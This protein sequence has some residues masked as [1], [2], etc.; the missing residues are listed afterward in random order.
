[1][2]NSHSLKMSIVMFVVHV[3]V[4]VY[5]VLLL[6]LNRQTA[7]SP[8]V[9]SPLLSAGGCN[10]NRQVRQTDRQTA[11]SPGVTSPLLSCLL[12]ELDTDRMPGDAPS[13]SAGLK[14][15]PSTASLAHC[16]LTA[17]LA[18]SWLTARSAV[19]STVCLHH[20]L[21]GL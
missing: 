8:G 9:T 4:S 2:V 20:S 6:F 19:S 13:P 7:N 15:E 21:L 10:N 16:W 12:E 5:Y 1:M 11:N 3:F 14:T 17:S 18:H